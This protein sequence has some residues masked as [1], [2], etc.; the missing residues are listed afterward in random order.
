M[1]VKSSMHG[2]KRLVK[3]LNFCMMDN[4]TWSTQHFTAIIF[5]LNHRAVFF[6]SA[7]MKFIMC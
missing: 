7:F 6:N 4:K 5:A 3:S 2:L 1:V